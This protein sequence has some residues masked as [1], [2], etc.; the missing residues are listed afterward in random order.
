MSTKLE[1]SQL[2][3]IDNIKKYLDEQLINYSIL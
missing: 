2:E 3:A 1:V